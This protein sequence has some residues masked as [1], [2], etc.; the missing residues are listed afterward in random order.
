MDC[1]SKGAVTASSFAMI[2]LEITTAGKAFKPESR[3]A[4][5]VKV[6]RWPYKIYVQMFS[7]LPRVQIQVQ[8][9]LVFPYWKSLDRRTLIGA[10]RPGAASLC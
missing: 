2:R 7:R 5:H 10:S 8:A 6:L 1:A 4:G 9:A 3:K